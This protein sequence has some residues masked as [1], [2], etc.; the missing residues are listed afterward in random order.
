VFSK[1]RNSQILVNLHVTNVPRCTS[2]DAKA[3]G[4]KNLQ[5]PEVAASGGDGARIVH[6]GAYELLI[7]Q[8]SV[9]G[10]ETAPPV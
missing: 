7:Q 10:G 3:L 5:L 4:L 8:N 1:E 6:H 9:P 2:S